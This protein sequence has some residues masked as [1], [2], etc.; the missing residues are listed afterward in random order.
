[1]AVPLFIFVATVCRFIED[2]G[3]LDP[4]RQLA[5]VLEYQ[6]RTQQSEIDKLDAMYRPVLDRLLTCPEA[7]RRS[8]LDEFCMVVGSIVLLAEP[9]SIR[10]LARLLYIYENVVVRRLMPLHSVLN[11]PASI[12]SPVRMFHLSFRDFLVD[13]NNCETNPFWVDEKASYERIAASCIKLLGS[14][15]KEDICKLRMPGTPCKD[16]EPAV[17]NSHFPSEVQYACRYWV[18]HL[19]QSSA[20]IIE[21]HP[22]FSFLKQHLLHWLEALSLLGK[23]S[24]GIAI[25]RSLQALISS[26]SGTVVSTFV[27]DATRF[28]LNF[29]S[30]IDLCPLQVY[31]SAIIFAPKKSEVRNIYERYIPRWVSLLPEV[32]TEW[33]ACLQTLEGHSHWVNSI[34]DPATGQCVATLKGHSHPVNSVAWSYDSSRLASASYDM[35][36]KIWGPATGQ[37]V[38]TFAIGKPLFSLQFD[39][40]SPNYLYT[41][42]GTF[43]LPPLK[44]SMTLSA[45]SHDSPDSL[46]QSV[47]YGLDDNGTWITY[48]GKNLLWLPQ[49]Y[50]PSSQAISGTAIAMGCRSGRVLVLKFFGECPVS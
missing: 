26:D 33:N 47:G 35:T 1:M 28:I 39:K 41:E 8:L 43:R 22:I 42:L 16:I 23:I 19:Q 11:V 31:S 10:S 20:R 4:A 14:H 50:R 32:D 24:E 13:P 36:V 45:T 18:Y 30:I 46:P 25:L 12:D 27:H 15:L 29:R 49:E 21:T 48:N 6:S 40:S 38:A 37:C 17:I 34:W 3:W 2:L 7:A 44:S 5:K 9:L